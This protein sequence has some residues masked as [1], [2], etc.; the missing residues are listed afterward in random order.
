MIEEIMQ[1][2]NEQI[3]S[4]FE[5]ILKDYHQ[6][7]DSIKH[8]VKPSRSETDV[9]KLIDEQGFKGVDKAKMGQLVEEIGIEESIEDL[10]AML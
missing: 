4:K 2:T 10:L 6:S 3:I 1:L 9:D 7:V 8:L 5:E